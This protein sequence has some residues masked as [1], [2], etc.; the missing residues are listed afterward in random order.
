MSS[1]EGEW[2]DNLRNGYGIEYYDT[3]DWNGRL[4]Y[5]GLW[6]NDKK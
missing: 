3:G 4:K 1:Y 6:V 2:K 5:E